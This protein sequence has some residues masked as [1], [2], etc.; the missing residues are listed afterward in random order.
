MKFFFKPANDLLAITSLLRLFHS[1]TTL[2][3]KE[4]F[5][6]SSLNSF[7]VTLIDDLLN[8]ILIEQKYILT[9]VIV[10][11]YYLKYL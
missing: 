4:Y 9:D 5:A 1:F 6:I 11:F 10:T 7:F 8:W 2:L 3:L